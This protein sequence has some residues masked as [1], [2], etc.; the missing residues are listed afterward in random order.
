M[1]C[2][3][4]QALCA[5]SI[6]G[7]DPAAPPQQPLHMDGPIPGPR[8]PQGPPPMGPPPPGSGPP[9]PMG[10][11]G[12][13]MGMPGPG[14]PPFLGPMIPPGMLGMPG[15]L[16]PGMLPP[17]MNGPM[18]PMGPPM[19]PPGMM[20]PMMGPR[21]PMGMGGG[22]PGGPFGGPGGMGGPR[23]P[24]PPPKPSGLGNELGSLLDRPSIRSL[25]KT[26]RCASQAESPRHCTELL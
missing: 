8:P 25:Q 26:E 16:P 17:G 9:G 6:V 23:V 20:G 4:R 3:T 1:C 12:P 2:Q 21:P 5:R 11:M 19:V 15:M 24:A 18:G 10:P 14:G 22:G 7:F 13:S